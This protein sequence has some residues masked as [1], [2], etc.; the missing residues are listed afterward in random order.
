MLNLLEVPPGDYRLR[1]TFVTEPRGEIRLHIGQSRGPLATWQVSAA[2]D[3]HRIRIPIT[4]S[5]LSIVGDAAAAESIRSVAL[6]PVRH[7]TTPWAAETRARA[8]ARY[9]R[10]V[11]YAIDNRVILESDGFWVLG[12]RQPDVVITT[13]RSQPEL[14][15]R[16]SNVGVRNRV[17]VSIGGWSAARELAPDERWLVTLP[18]PDWPQPAVV[19]VR[20]EQ[21]VMVAGQPLGCLVSIVE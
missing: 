17:R 16:V 21:G 20:V 8:S 19:N 4:A 10:S 12:G 6:V 18:L 3:A 14:T 13:D 5:V 2:D 11:V 9:G 15:L 1:L 7:I